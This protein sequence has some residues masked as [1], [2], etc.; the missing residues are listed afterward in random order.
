M[1][2]RAP[3]LPEFAEPM[4]RQRS[5]T[6]RRDDRS[7]AENSCIARVS[8]AHLR[9]YSRGFLGHFS[10][11]APCFASIP[12]AAESGANAVGLERGVIQ[13][14]VAKPLADQPGLPTLDSKRVTAGS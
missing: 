3:I 11:F 6:L 5:V 2:V 13:V 9:A 10:H 8:Y 7:V 12:H 1:R 4:P 14:P